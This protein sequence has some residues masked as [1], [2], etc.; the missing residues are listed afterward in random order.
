MEGERDR[1]P[2]ERVNESEAMHAEFISG[3]IPIRLKNSCCQWLDSCVNAKDLHGP[4][5]AEELTHPHQRFDLELNPWGGWRVV[6]IPFQAVSNTL[7]I[8]SSR[9]NIQSFLNLECFLS[10]QS[11]QGNR[12][13]MDHGNPAPR[14]GARLHVG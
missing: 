7:S 9:N 10:E 12:E 11:E 1:G 5:A 4:A 8:F 14:I 6:P 3:T 2:S 13:S